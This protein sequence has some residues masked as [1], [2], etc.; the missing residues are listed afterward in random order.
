MGSNLGRSG[1]K[2]AIDSTG[3][4][5][6]HCLACIVVDVRTCGF[7]QRQKVLSLSLQDVGQD[8]LLTKQPMAWLRGDNFYH[9][10]MNRVGYVTGDTV[11]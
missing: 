2:Q 4:K 11:A 6:A 7:K 9:Q 1:C 10:T 5:S 3:V 8:N